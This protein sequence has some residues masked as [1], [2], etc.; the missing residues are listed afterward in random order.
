MSLGDLQDPMASLGY[1]LL[2]IRVSK[3]D[4]DLGIGA[5]NFL[6]LW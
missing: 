1:C 5:S 6:F 3:D 4:G 2:C